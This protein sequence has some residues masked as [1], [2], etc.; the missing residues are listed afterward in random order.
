MFIGGYLF[1]FVGA[2]VRWMY[3]SI[4]RTIF[5]KPKY[6][7]KEYLHGPANSK[8]WFDETAHGFNN[9]IIGLITIVGLCWV[10]VKLRI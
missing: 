5:N 8:D 1:E 2:V 4:W 7:F 3:G 6:K 10:I 9:R